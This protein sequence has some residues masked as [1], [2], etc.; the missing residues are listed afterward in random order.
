MT[1]T[2]QPTNHQLTDANDTPSNPPTDQPTKRKGGR[3]SKDAERE[4]MRA[5]IEAEMDV[6]YLREVDMK[7]EAMRKALEEKLRAE[8]EGQIVELKKK[9]VRKPREPKPI[10]YWEGQV[11][12]E[13]GWKFDSKESAKNYAKSLKGADLMLD[14]MM[15]WDEPFAERKE[16]TTGKRSLIMKP[17]KEGLTDENRCETR[18]WNYKDGYAQRCNNEGKFTRG[19]HKI[20]KRCNSAADNHM[21]MYLDWEEEFGTILGWA[22]DDQSVIDEILLKHKKNPAY[23]PKRRVR[24][25]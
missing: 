9:P 17:M 22:T 5:E 4:A 12:C 1:S 14:F 24:K 19:T 6:R 11:E 13:G 25:V 3:K 18:K 15:D 21:N 10:I 7:V 2:N 16:K 8:Y 20:C 23:E